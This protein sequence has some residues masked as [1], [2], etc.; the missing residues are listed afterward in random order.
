MKMLAHE[1]Y[2]LKNPNKK[3]LKELGFKYS[4]DMSDADND[5]YY[6]KFP[7]LKYINT[8]TIEGEIIID[9]NSGCVRLNTYKYG[10]KNC[11]S[12]FYQEYSEVNKLILKD[13]NKA[14]KNMFS[15]IGIE[16]AGVK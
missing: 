13:I 2:I 3:K 14:F 6:I 12:P 11:Y 4:K 10:T 5:S 7:I 15:K 1:K 16:K 9:I 8:P